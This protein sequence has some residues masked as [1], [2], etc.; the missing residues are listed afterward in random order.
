MAK[1]GDFKVA[2]IGQDKLTPAATAARRSTERLTHSQKGLTTAA[3]AA[4]KAFKLLSPYLAGGAIVAGMTKMINTTAELGDKF[5][6]M[7]QKLGVSV[8]TLSTFDHVAKL[9]GT[10][11]DVVGVGLRR[12]AQNALDMSRGIGEAKREFEAL[13]ISVTDSEGKVRTM[14]S[15]LLDVADRFSKMEDGT[16]KTAMAMRLFGRSGSEMIPMLNAGKEGLHDMMQEAERLGVVFSED[17]ARAAEQFNDNMTRLKTG[18][19]GLMF[20]VG[21]EVI[22]VM[23]KFLNVLGFGTRQARE[24]LEGEITLIDRRITDLRESMA[25]GQEWF[26]PMDPRAFETSTEQIQRQERELA[27]LITTRNDLRA[28]L[29]ILIE[30]EQALQNTMVTGNQTI[31][32]HG[33]NIEN[34]SRTLEEAATQY[35]RM[36]Q[37]YEKAKESWVSGIEEQTGGYEALQKSHEEEQRR[38]TQ[39]LHALH[40]LHAGV[41]E[42][43]AR[44]R[45]DFRAVSKEWE[46]A[47]DILERGLVSA[48]DSV[49][50]AGQSLD[51]TMRNVFRNL[52]SYAI[53]YAVRLILVRQLQL[54]SVYRSGRDGGSW[55]GLG[56]T[57]GSL[58]GS[59]VPGIGTLIGGVL[60]A[61]VGSLFHEGGMVGTTGHAMRAHRGLM[62]GGLRG[63]ERLAIV[64]TG[65]GILSRRGVRMIGGPEGVDAVNAGRTN[66]FGNIVINAEMGPVNSMMD[67]EEMGQVLGQS[68]LSTIRESV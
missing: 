44:T 16:T 32:D 19:R 52:A 39:R 13:G 14:E 29:D 28:Q 63:D 7:S 43:T 55:G 38:L 26:S 12:F 8:E 3:N 10:T 21:N 50:W 27:R 34:L 40:L 65:E 66:N 53:Q 42:Q 46:R 1:L 61:V 15:L 37:M 56:G 6:K 30:R 17:T 68:F 11:I 49:I 23:T 31:S 64:Q 62:I 47:T 57:I 41:R 5:A 51:V 59:I 48:I 35:E 22:P 54:A 18:L 24:T 25:E 33:Q 45:E 58:I 4:G 20:T 36:Q 60:G 67:V 2:I 9:S